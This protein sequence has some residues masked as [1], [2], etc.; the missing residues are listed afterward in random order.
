M[1]AVAQR[2]L[3]DRQQHDEQLGAFQA[4][5]YVAAWTRFPSSVVVEPTGDS[6]DSILFA[7]E[8]ELHL[9]LSGLALGARGRQYEEAQ[10]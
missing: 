3:R 8:F 4:L 7:S 2:L 9:W 1:S 6:A 10:R 5:G